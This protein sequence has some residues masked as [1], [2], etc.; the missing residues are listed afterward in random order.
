M[1]QILAGGGKR[2]LF[3]WRFGVHFGGDLQSEKAGPHIVYGNFI[4]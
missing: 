3:C 4:T 2:I 1:Y